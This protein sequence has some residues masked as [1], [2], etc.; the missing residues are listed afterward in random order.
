[1]RAPG[2]AAATGRFNPEAPEETPCG[3]QPPEA[4]DAAIDTRSSA[5]RSTPVSVQGC[6]VKM[7]NL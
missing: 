2:R 5:E 6:V 7:V 4:A 3:S 1:M